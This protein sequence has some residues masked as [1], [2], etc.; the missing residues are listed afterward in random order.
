MN[1][2]AHFQW[3]EGPL[4]PVVETVLGVLVLWGA[5]V[6]GFLLI[7]GEGTQWMLVGAEGVAL[8]GIV[9]LHSMHP[10]VVGARRVLLGAAVLGLLVALLGGVELWWP[11]ILISLAAAGFVLRTFRGAWIYPAPALIVMFFMEADGLIE[12]IGYA[13]FLVLVAVVWLGAWIVTALGVIASK[14]LWRD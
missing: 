13:L 3:I 12:Y 10:E 8:G 6:A 2:H 7:S 5:Q 11:L 9:L 4:P 1:A 14:A